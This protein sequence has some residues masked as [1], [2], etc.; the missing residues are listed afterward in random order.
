MV[1]AV[2]RN[3]A[4]LRQERGLSQRAAAADLG[5]SQALLSHYENGIREP[6]LAFICKACDYYQVSTD[7][8][9][10]RSSVRESA[11]FDPHVI[12][13]TYNKE[14][15][16]NPNKT[17]ARFYCRVLNNAMVIIFDLLAKI[18]EEKA[19]AA[20]YQFIG[21]AIYRL[22][23]HLTKYAPDGITTLMEVED[24]DMTIRASEADMV[25]SEVQLLQC[26][27][28]RKEEKKPFPDAGY[29]ILEKNYPDQYLSLFEIVYSGGKRN[30]AMMDAHKDESFRR[31]K[32]HIQEKK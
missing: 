6:G 22:Y 17:L 2:A 1:S 10:G 21:T 26:L 5:I 16:K 4:L 19:I 11:S 30:Q 14:R 8:L 3:L 12:Y 15:E 18:Q 28:K 7:Y 27:K 13:K 25:L 20:A 32:N 29:K 24:I 9:L 23:R 31:L